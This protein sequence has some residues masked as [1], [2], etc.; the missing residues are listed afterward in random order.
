MDDD[1][2]PG[3]TG[4][5]S[6]L[7]SGE[8]KTSTPTP[9][10]A[11]TTMAREQQKTAPDLTARRTSPRLPT[12][13]LAVSSKWR[14]T[15]TVSTMSWRPASALDRMRAATGEPG[16]CAARAASKSRH[17]LVWSARSG[18]LLPPTPL[19]PL[20]LRGEGR[21][22]CCAIEPPVA[23]AEE[24]AESGVRSTIAEAPPATPPPPPPPPP[25]TGE[26]LRLE[27]RVGDV[28][29]APPPA[30]LIAPAAAG[31]VA[32]ADVE[33][34]GGGSAAAPTALVAAATGPAAA[35]AGRC[36]STASASGASFRA[37]GRVPGWAA[38]PTAAPAALPG[39]PAAWGECARGTTT[40]APT[41]F[42]LPSPWPTSQGERR[43]SDAVTRVVGSGS[44]SPAISRLASGETASQSLPVTQT[45]GLPS[46]RLNSGKRA[47]SI[48]CST[49]PRDQQSTGLPYL[50]E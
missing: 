47:T 1:R 18:L 49:A 44:I 46:D 37:P 29:A 42:P 41:P 24:E 40:M 13:S 38:A 5:R 14:S 6:L 27:V 36:P 3:C 39:L 11:T 23:E 8:R 25:T 15:A 28:C 32:A 30:A 26:I 22:C 12:T 17:T 31:P 34:A 50:G 4:R 19:S 16:G 2:P 10:T 48:T 35:A 9:A 43:A 45:R 20:P 21:T 7:I 33:M